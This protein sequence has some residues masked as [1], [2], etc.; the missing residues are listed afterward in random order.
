MEP[1]LI[2][3][4]LI[5]PG[6]PYDIT[7]TNGIK[8]VIIQ[9]RKTADPSITRYIIY[10]HNKEEKIEIIPTTSLIETVTISNLLAGNYN[11]EILAM[12]E[13][14]NRSKSVFVSASV[15]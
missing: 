4:N 5:Y 15:D 11:F 6:A 3:G 9:F 13:M 10:W 7:I 1:Y 14:G 2:D 12:D 8:S